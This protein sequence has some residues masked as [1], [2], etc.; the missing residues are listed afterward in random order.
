MFNYLV[1]TDSLKSATASAVTTTWSAASA[2]V[3]VTA[4]STASTAAALREVVR[5]RPTSAPAVAVFCAVSA[6]ARVRARRARGLAWER[7]DSSRTGASA[8]VSVG[9]EHR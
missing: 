1:V 7:D 4:E 2:A 6:G 9:R 3:T 8:P 5:E